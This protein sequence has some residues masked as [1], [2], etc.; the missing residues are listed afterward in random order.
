MPKINLVEFACIIVETGRTLT[1]TY[2]GW[3]ASAKRVASILCLLRIL[4]LY[5]SLE[6]SPSVS[7]VIK[8]LPFYVSCDSSDWL[9]EC[10]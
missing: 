2:I 3:L 4:F 10:S 8:L 1:L 7:S 5:Y 6:K 9:A